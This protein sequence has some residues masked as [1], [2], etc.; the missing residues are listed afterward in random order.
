MAAPVSGPFVRIYDLPY[1]YSGGSVSQVYAYQ[2]RSRQARP[3][4][5]PLPYEM[6]VGKTI[7]RVGYP[8]VNNQ[9]MSARLMVQAGGVNPTNLTVDLANRCYDKIKSQMSDRAEM[10]VAVIEFEKSLQMIERRALQLAAAA[11]AIRKGNFKA[12]AGLLVH[13]P[14]KKRWRHG[15]PSTAKSMASN[16]LE[17]SYGWAP[18]ANDIGNAIDVLQSPLKGTRISASVSDSGPTIYDGSPTP[19]MYFNTKR[20]DVKKRAVRMG[21]EVSVSNPNLWLANQLG[22]INPASIFWET[23]PFSFVV[24]W[25][26]NVSQFLGSGTDFIGLS[27][28]NPYTSR[29]VAGSM[30]S[31]WGPP[32]YG[33]SDFTFWKMRRELGLTSP[34]LSL[35]P[36]WLKSWGRALN[37]SS[38]LTMQ[39]K[40]LR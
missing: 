12:A 19:D 35:K 37:A 17:F 7:N 6:Y 18:S 36:A 15:P 27:I 24:D 34:V 26:A 33:R 13:G 32:W 9:P 21:C 23:V 2:A 16:W 4:N 40:S 30:S 3:I 5:Q 28:V 1:V 8:E 20:W 31:Y 11:I 10:G 22:F 14:D 29:Y 39:L 25:F 38:L